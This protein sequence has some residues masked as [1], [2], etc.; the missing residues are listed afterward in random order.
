M[1]SM[2]IPEMKF[3]ELIYRENEGGESCVYSFGAVCEREYFEYMRELERSGYTRRDE[4]QLAKNCVTVFEKDGD[5][6]LA[7]YYPALKEARI[8]TEP[9]SA[10]L[11]F[12][13]TSRAKKTTPLM[14]Q[15]DLEDFGTS[16][17]FRLA[18]GR[19]IVFDGG[20]EFE[21]DADK[22]VACLNEQS[23]GERPT[24]A[25]WVM[26]HPHCDHYRCFITAYEK[27]PDA[28]TV[29][30]F[31]YSFTDTEESDFERIPGLRKESEQVRVFE[32]LVKKT[33]ASV[34]KAHTG[35]VYEI[36]GARLEML[37]TPDDTL[38]TPVKDINSLSLVV[39]MT[40]AGQVIM[41]CA[42]AF[43]G[44]MN[45]AGRYG[46]YLK[47]DILQPPHHMFIGG[48]IDAYNFIDPSVCVVPSFEAD[49]FARI[50]PY[51]NVCKTENLHLFYNMNV[52]EFFTGSTGNVVLTLPYKP[53]SNGRKLYLDKISEYRRSMGANT[54]FYMD[55]TAEDCDFTFVNTSCETATVFV[56]LYGEDIPTGYIHA[57][58]LNVPPTKTSRFNILN[59]D[60]A[61][62]DALYYNPHSL[63]KKGIKDGASFTAQFKSDIPIVVKGNKPA[64]YHD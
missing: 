18:D 15:I 47:S 23:A 27:Y 49:V 2:N 10:Y 24:V 29:E 38:I 52:E 1:D 31:I 34:Y 59:P 22:L 50:S 63:A 62:A 28:F 7:V 5:M 35:Q 16:V 19:F 25:A 48:N 13:D 54:W 41:L 51:Q 4:Y 17:V 46:E 30:R 20:R 61:D 8:V 40:V 64:D 60:D 26:T 39:K 11:S 21:P 14:T 33:G 45:L 3:G 43:L 56:E 55:I 57:I 53:R 12:S 32:N 9:S 44:A 42:D 36:G 37:S 58:K 6:L